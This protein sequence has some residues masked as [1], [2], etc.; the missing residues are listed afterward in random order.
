MKTLLLDRSQWDLVKG[1]DG[2]IAVAS[3][4]YSII[5]DAASAART[6]RGEVWYDVSLGVPFFE[7][8]LGHQPALEV[9]RALIVA[10]VE[11][12][13]GVASATL[14]VRGVKGRTLT[15]QIQ[16]TTTTGQKLV[17]T[18]PGA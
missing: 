13:P 6:F 11:A 5:Q 4:P 18:L 17:A 3:D 10:E 1:L 8:I 7:E 15:G 9:V 16:V 14:F 2:S 12:V